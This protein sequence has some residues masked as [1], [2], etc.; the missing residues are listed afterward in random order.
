MSMNR[1]CVDKLMVDKNELTG[2]ESSHTVL[3][4][5]QL[6]ISEQ[7]CSVLYTFHLHRFTEYNI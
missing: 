6:K 4:L 7:Q 5:S 1:K 3:L 2:E